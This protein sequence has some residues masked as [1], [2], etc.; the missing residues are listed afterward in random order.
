MPKYGEPDPPCPSP[1]S[2]GHALAKFAE[3]IK[4]ITI[5]A[6]KGKGI[7]NLRCTPLYNTKVYFKDTK[8]KSDCEIFSILKA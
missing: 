5:V 1:G 3:S 7:K 6:K 2:N 8:K 4:P